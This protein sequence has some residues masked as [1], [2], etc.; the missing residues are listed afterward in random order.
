MQCVS[1]ICGGIDD[2][3]YYYDDKIIGI[4]PGVPD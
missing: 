4:D 3:C 1:G 2:E